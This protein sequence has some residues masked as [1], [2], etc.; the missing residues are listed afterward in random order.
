MPILD[1]LSQIFEIEKGLDSIRFEKDKPM[2]Q[3][4]FTKDFSLR[5]CWSSNAI[6]GNTLNLEETVSVIEYDEVKGGH[7]YTEYQEAKNL[8]QAI[9]QL[10]IPFQEKEITEE[11][12]KEANGIILGTKSD[13]RKNPVYIGTLVEAVYY[14]PNAEEVP[15]LMEKFIKEIQFKADTVKEALEKIAE[16]HIR[17]E[18]IHPFQDGN[19]RVGRMILNQQLINNGLLPVSI[20]PKGKYR[21]AF[22]Q[23]DKNKDISLMTYAICKGELESIHNIQELIKRRSRLL[24]HQK[25]KERTPKL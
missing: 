6:E 4:P 3:D 22:R 21:Q 2:I 25:R 8:Y 9:S 15:A 1:N 7:T 18:R 23:Y 5:F 20:E 11:W 12:I 17:F 24:N 13:Y 19:G 16:M 14:P 10:L